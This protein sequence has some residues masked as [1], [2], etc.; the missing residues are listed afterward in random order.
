MKK[1]HVLLV[2]LQQL[3]T[4][5]HFGKAPR[6]MHEQR[7][8]NVRKENRQV[9]LFIDSFAGDL[10]EKLTQRQSHEPWDTQQ[11][12]GNAIVHGEW[13]KGSI[14]GIKGKDPAFFADLSTLFLFFRRHGRSRR[15]ES[16]CGGKKTLIYRRVIECSC[17]KQPLGWS[18]GC[19]CEGL[20]RINERQGDGRTKLHGEKGYFWEGGKE[21]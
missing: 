1:Q 14:L 7:S 8:P 9:T 19:C 17:G 20:G 2:E 18:D 5:F 3:I 12:S 4:P 11:N 13:I 15:Q 16:R 10:V 6:E 21:K